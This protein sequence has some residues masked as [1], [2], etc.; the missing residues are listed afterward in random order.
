[1]MLENLL[2]FKNPKKLKVNKKPDSMEQPQR[3]IAKCR[4]RSPP[5]RIRK[6]MKA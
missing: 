5:V 3:R 2:F 1:M 6:G 4:F